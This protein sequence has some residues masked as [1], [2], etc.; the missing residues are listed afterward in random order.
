MAS[1]Q[2]TIRPTKALARAL[3]CRPDLILLDDIFSGL[4]R[5]SA[6]HIFSALFSQTGL[7]ARLH[8]AVALATHSS[9]ITPDTE[10]R[11]RMFANEQ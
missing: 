8:C 3:Y 4:D 2:L 6:Q 5:K 11:Q 1:H 9:A 7:L 10:N